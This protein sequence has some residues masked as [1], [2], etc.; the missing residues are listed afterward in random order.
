MSRRV[1]TPGNG[2]CS[3]QSSFASCS[4]TAWA[5]ILVKAKG[6]W[7]L[8]SAWLSGST[9]A[10]IRCAI[11]GYFS[12]VFRRPRAEKLSTQEIPLRCSWSPLFTASRPQP[13]TSSA[14]RGLPSQYRTATSAWN[15]RRRAPVS[16]LAADRI[17]SRIDAVSSSDIAS[18]LRQTNAFPPKTRRHC[19]RST[20]ESADQFRVHLDGGKRSASPQKWG[21]RTAAW[22]DTD[23]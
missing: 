3:S 13:N 1:R 15:C 11:S 8:G 23:C 12:S 14:R 20:R 18:S 21:T 2:E 16:F 7:N 5:V 19:H 6:V 17:V 4:R 9:S 10:S 22:S